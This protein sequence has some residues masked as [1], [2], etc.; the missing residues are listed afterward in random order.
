MIGAC[1][2]VILSKRL[3]STGGGGRRG[4]GRM[5]VGK[6]TSAI[7]AYRR[8]PF[9]TRCARYNHYVIKFVSDL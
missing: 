9:M 8:T 3:V 1:K 7:S 4:R 5:V 2:V 6:T